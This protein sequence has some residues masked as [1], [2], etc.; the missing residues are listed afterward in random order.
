MSD[1]PSIREG[2]L[3]VGPLFSEPMQVETVRQ[4]A[5]G[6]WILGLVG[7]RTQQFRRVTLTPDE[8]RLLRVVESV[9]SIDGDPNLLRL[10]L[11]AYALG[12]AY[13]F[14][15]Y[16]GLFEGGPGC[17]DQNRRSIS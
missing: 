14:D 13:E 2:Q 10:G 4:S 5:P 16:F 12:I 15:P 6:T 11:Q 3:L 17:Q 7:S 1:A 9:R 8:F